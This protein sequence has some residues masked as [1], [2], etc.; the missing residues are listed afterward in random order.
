MKMISRILGEYFK[1]SY[2]KLRK[3]DVYMYMIRGI[4]LY[5]L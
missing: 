5:I 2:V 1:K 4:L 3:K